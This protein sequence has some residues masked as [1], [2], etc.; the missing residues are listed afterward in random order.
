M[1][2]GADGVVSTEELVAL[3]WAGDVRPADPAVEPLLVTGADRPTGSHGETAS[4]WNETTASGGS[5]GLAVEGP[6]VP[7]VQLRFP[8]VGPF[9]W[10]PGGHELVFVAGDTIQSWD[11]TKTTEVTQVQ[12]GQGATLTGIAGFTPDLR[13]VSRRPQRHARPS[14]SSSPVAG[15][16]AGA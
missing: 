5:G 2:A 10:R 6:N 11:G 7:R 14:A 12:G 8:E 13:A 3:S 4:Q 15:G 1:P 9:A 16:H